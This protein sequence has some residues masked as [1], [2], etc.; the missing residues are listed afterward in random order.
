MDDEPQSAIEERS[1]TTRVLVVDDDDAIR[2]L[3]ARVFVRR[4]FDVET[5]KDGADAIEA[6]DARAFDLLLLD[7]MMPRVDGIG[8]IEHLAGRPDPAPRVIVMTAA[9]PDILKRMDHGQIAAVIA[10]PFE[11]PE[12][13]RTAEEVLAAR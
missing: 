8:V 7:L 12:L 4:G 1:A 9:V 13:L 6:L 2:T 11:L 10:K 5:A 3:V